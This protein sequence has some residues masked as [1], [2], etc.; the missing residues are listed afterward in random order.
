MGTLRQKE[1]L[2]GLNLY[3][4]KKP[5]SRAAAIPLQIRVSNSGEKVG[6]TGTEVPVG[7][8]S[9]N[10]ENKITTAYRAWA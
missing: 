1:S 4:G 8:P 9:N 2:E 3:P 5:V 7:L 10:T 6:G